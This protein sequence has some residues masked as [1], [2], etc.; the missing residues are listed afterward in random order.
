MC[1][2][3]TLLGTTRAPSSAE[4]REHED[5]EVAAR[6]SKWKSRETCNFF[7]FQTPP[8]VR[9][10][11]F[12]VAI[13]RCQLIDV[14]VYRCVW[15]FAALCFNAAVPDAECRGSVLGTAGVAAAAACR[16]SDGVKLNCV[17]IHLNLV[18]SL[19][20]S[21]RGSH[22]PPLF[23]LTNVFFQVFIKLKFFFVCLI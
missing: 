17:F 21:P 18:L 13:G 6:R 4:A 3:H 9:T 15:V 7:W 2:R 11:V 10:G 22:L 5:P 23:L 14:I 8:Q 19:T 12:A 16:W 1:N 20:V